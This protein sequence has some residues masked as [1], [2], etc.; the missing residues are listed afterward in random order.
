MMYRPSKNPKVLDLIKSH[1]GRSKDLSALRPIKLEEL[2][3]KG[4]P[5]RFCAWCTEVEL[6]H[7]NQ[8]YCSR[9]CSDSAMAVFYPQKE[10]A[11]RFLLVRQDWKCN[12]CQFDYKPIMEEMMRQERARSSY[13][14]EVNTPLDDLEWYYFKRLKGLTPYDRKPEVDH[15]L[16]I[17]KGGTALGL[18]NHQV[19]CYTC[20]KNKTKVDLSGKRI[21]KA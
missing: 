19:L 15:V 11:L 5:R 6:F 4:K 21:K 2:N 9:Q 12:D 16:A 20:H 10:H 7:G 17:S 3:E 14:A 13:A 8:K 18:D 1:T